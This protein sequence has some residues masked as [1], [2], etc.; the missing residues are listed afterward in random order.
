VVEVTDPLGEDFELFKKTASSPPVNVLTGAENWAKKRL[1]LSKLPEGMKQGEQ[2]AKYFDRYSMEWFAC[3]IIMNCDL[4]RKELES[5]SMQK[6]LIRA[7]EVGWL[8]SYVS[9]AQEEQR[10]RSSGGDKR[11]KPFG[12]AKKDCIKLAKVFW[13][14]NPSFGLM[15]LSEMIEK[16]LIADKKKSPAARTIYKYLLDARDQGSLPVRDSAPKRGRPRK[17]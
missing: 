3:E 5:G 10:Q 2:C 6:A 1:D 15:A 9:R 13:P 14:E 8:I 11:G 7:G 12:D 16:V 4:M 17:T